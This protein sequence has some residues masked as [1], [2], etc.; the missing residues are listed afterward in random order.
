MSKAVKSA[1]KMMKKVPR[2]K[3]IKGAAKSGMRK[4]GKAAGRMTAKKAIKGA[5]KL[6]IGQALSKVNKK[7]H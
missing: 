5:A 4:A 6:G 2:R 3:Y 1:T 7:W